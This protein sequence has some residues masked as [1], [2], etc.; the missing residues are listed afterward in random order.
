MN[1]A[2]TFII[3]LLDY[4]G[5][6]TSHFLFYHASSLLHGLY[7]VEN[8]PSFKLPIFFSGIIQAIK[9]NNCSHFSE[10]HVQVSGMADLAG[11]PPCLLP[12]RA[13]R[14]FYFSFLITYLLCKYLEEILSFLTIGAIFTLLVFCIL[15]TEKGMDSV[16]QKHQIKIHCREVGKSFCH[17]PPTC[18]AGWYQKGRERA[19]SKG[20][21]TCRA[22]SSI[23][24]VKTLPY[25]KHCL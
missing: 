2:Q 25:N 7:L 18:W 12:T 11:L 8:K 20:T 9:Q 23:L 16:Q 13:T 21:S 22:L 4:G 19:G 1:Q 17:H 14:C 6:V 10:G 15:S 5:S 3:M 24:S